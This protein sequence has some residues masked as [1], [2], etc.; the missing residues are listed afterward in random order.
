LT[1]EEALTSLKQ[2]FATKSVDLPD[3]VERKAYELSGQE[4]LFDGLRSDYHGF[5]AWF[6]KC[7]HDHRDCW[8]LELDGEV[9]GLVIRKNEDHDAAKTRH[10]GPKILKVCTFKVR[11]EFQGEKFGDLL[12]KQVLW[13]APWGRERRFEGAT[14]ARRAGTLIC[15]ESITL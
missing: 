2:S 9:A 1:V 13:H 14:L 15:P 12:L 11:E 8:V 7:K 6:E 3:V 5:D 10:A 4:L